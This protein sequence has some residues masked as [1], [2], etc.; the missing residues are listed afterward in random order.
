MTPASKPNPMKTI[1][2]S[3]LGYGS[4]LA[5]AAGLTSSAIA[6]PGPQYWAHRANDA[7]NR[8]AKTETAK[9]SETRAMACLNCKTVDA[10]EY[11]PSMAG[12]KVPSRYDKVGA[13]HT[14]STCGGAIS[15]VRG[16]TTSDMKG[17]CP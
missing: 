17:N 12:G 8:P 16:K 1:T 10:T 4:A 7:K 15:T 3:I 6:G 5:L 2:K 9:P 14:C 13:K 11:R